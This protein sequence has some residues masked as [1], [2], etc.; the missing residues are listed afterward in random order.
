MPAWLF[1]PRPIAAS[2]IL[3]LALTVGVLSRHFECRAAS[4]SVHTWRT[5]QGLPQNAITAI[6]QARQGYLWVG[7]YAGLARFDGVRFKVLDSES[8]PGLKNDRITGLFEAP[9]EALWICHETGE[10]TRL[11]NGTFQS[12]TTPEGV[13]N[14][15]TLSLSADDRGDVWALNTDGAL[16]RLKDGHLIPRPE[17]NRDGWGFPV[18]AR[19][20]AGN[21]WLGRGGEIGLIREG[22]FERVQP[23][24][25]PRAHYIQAMC[26]SRSG[27]IWVLCDQRL[28]RLQDGK[29]VAERVTDAEVVH[30]ASS[31]LQE[32]RD[33]TLAV[34][35]WN[36]GVFLL[37]P[38]GS[39]QKFSRTNGL[40]ANWIRSF[41][42]DRE[43]NFRLGDA[44]M[45]GLTVLR[46]VNFQQLAP[47]DN[48]EGKPCM[49]VAKDHLGALW[50]GTEGAGV[51]CLRAG[52]WSRHLYADDVLSNGQTPRFVWTVQTDTEGTLWVGTW[53]GG[54]FRRVSERFENVAG[55]P[56][57]V[58]ISAIFQS[59][60]GAIWCGTQ[61]GLVRYAGGQRTSYGTRQGLVFPDVRAITQTRDGTIWFGMAGG[62]LGCL[63]NGTCKQY[64]KDDGLGSDFVRCLRAD[65]KGGLWMGT[66][67]N[68]LNRFRDGRFRRISTPEGLPSNTIG[69]IQED[70]LGNWW[71][72]SQV[73]VLCV[74]RKDLELCADGQIKRVS[75]RAYGAADG[76]PTSEC[77]SGFQPVSCRT[78]DGRLYFPTRSGLVAVDPSHLQ[79]NALP[80]PVLIE[81]LNVDGRHFASPTNGSWNGTVTVRIPPGHQRYEFRY[82]ALSLSAP[83][84]VRFKYR[85]DRWEQDWMESSDRSAIYSYLP[86]GNYTF[87]VIACNNDGVWNLTGATLPITVL[88]HF[89]QTWWFR[90]LAYL[91]GTASVAA[92]VGGV[93]WQRHRRKINRLEQQQAL[94]RERLRIARDIH[95]DMGASLTRIM[96]LSQ[97]QEK[98]DEAS[99]ANSQLERIFDTAS[100]L[101]TTVDEIVWAVNPEHDTLASLANY[102]AN[103]SQE[104]LAPTG[105]RCRLELP[106]N[107][108][109]R[110]LPAEWR[111]NL[112]LAFKEAMNN[113]VKHAAATQVTI[114]LS[115]A[116]NICR[117]TVKDNGRGF[118]LEAHPVDT[119]PAGGNGLASM[120][121]RMNR[122]GGSWDV[123]SRPGEG[124]L[125][126]FEV[127]LPQQ[128]Q[129]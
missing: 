18:L 7:S 81:N 54:L 20:H 94:Q 121:Q 13:R 104:F 70:D 50:V 127:R 57:S 85:L 34:G 32:L 93:S 91:A 99:P 69:D 10:L 12:V 31:F 111:H 101:T 79:T 98:P 36:Q 68:G 5:E 45:G 35:N 89:W 126:T 109:P 41:C 92:V 84:K 15:K 63:T 114:M 115:V 28:R 124:T 47:P 129:A 75:C 33:G 48:W 122:L 71:L 25:S 22:H 37:N 87:H 77:S 26:T 95:D 53:G 66:T 100:D 118:C 52:K 105:I 106:L 78:E 108:P 6:V 11:T 58:P 80:P 40:S 16:A 72:A 55:F 62:G 8:T 49:S 39:R 1:S 90:V 4:Y 64:R 65:S 44:S 29:W 116:E 51:Y 120:R 119:F 88:P 42:E 117:L 102:I 73:G 27:G 24:P 97:T 2:A 125:V 56:G 82:T 46:P 17:I 86:P 76:L 112:F 83:E 123:H 23:E 30:G 21:L 61:E 14:G 74:A 67:G 60:D 38:D 59:Q 19:D 107:L 113:I 103:Y 43:G 110:I 96:M 128:V 9:D 3:S